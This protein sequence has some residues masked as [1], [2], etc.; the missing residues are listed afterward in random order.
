MTAQNGH[1]TKLQ[2]MV[3][4]FSAAVLGKR[5]NGPEKFMNYC[6]FIL[7]KG[8]AGYGARGFEKSAMAEVPQQSFAS[9][10]NRRR[11]PLP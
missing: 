5:P 7:R 10:R 3:R 1:W 9:N 6:G 11:C 8:P 2:L 4:F